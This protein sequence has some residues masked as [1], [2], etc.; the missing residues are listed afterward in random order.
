MNT[1]D[2]RLS[3]RIAIGGCISS[4]KSTLINAICT[5]TYSDM[6]RKRTT[7]KPQ[8]YCETKNELDPI[9]LNSIRENNKNDNS[10]IYK[11]GSDLTIDDIT[12]SVYPIPRIPDFM[13]LH[14]ECY[15]DLY[16]L[17]GLNDSQTQDVFFQYIDRNHLDFDMIIYIVDVCSALNTTDEMNILTKFL[18]VI[19]L[20]RNSYHV[21]KKNTQQSRISEEKKPI[22]CYNFYVKAVYPKIKKELKLQKNPIDEGINEKDFVFFPKGDLHHE[23]RIINIAT[24]VVYNMNL[25][26]SLMLKN[27]RPHSKVTQKR[28]RQLINLGLRADIILSQRKNIKSQDIICVAASRWSSMGVSEKE[29]WQYKYIAHLESEDNFDSDTI[30]R[31]PPPIKPKQIK[32]LVVLNKID[33]ISMLDSNGD[34]ELDEEGKELI[35]QAQEYITKE[36]KRRQL[37]EQYLGTT[38]LCAADAYI[39]RLY[40][41]NPNVKLDINHINRFGMN[42]YGKRTWSRF[43]SQQKEDKVRQLM[44]DE[45]GSNYNERMSACGFTNLKRIIN[46]SFSD[47]HQVK[48]LLHRLTRHIHKNINYIEGPKE[49]LDNEIIKWQRIFKALSKVDS[50]YNEITSVPGGEYVNEEER[51]SSIVESDPTE[52]TTQ[53]SVSNEIL[54]KLIQTNIIQQF[55]ATYFAPYINNIKDIYCSVLDPNIWTED[56]YESQREY[57]DNLVIIGNMLNSFNYDSEVSQLI[58]DVNKNLN[59]Y[60]EFSARSSHSFSELFNKLDTLVDNHYADIYTLTKEI[61]FGLTGKITNFSIGF[62]KSGEIIN[63][64]SH[65]YLQFS[66][67]EQIEA[68]QEFVINYLDYIITT[69]L[70]NEEPQKLIDY[71]CYLYALRIYTKHNRLAII[72]QNF[73]DLIENLVI[74]AIFKLTTEDAIFLTSKQ[75]MNPNELPEMDI[76]KHLLALNSSELAANIVKPIKL[77]EEYSSFE[78]DRNPIGYRIPNSFNQDTMYIRKQIMKKI[79]EKKPFKSPNYNNIL[80]INLN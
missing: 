52:G 57:R 69:D 1:I 26:S 43:T 54:P 62:R 24:G 19:Q 6:Q 53:S 77:E 48:L 41:Q 37:G 39:Y 70:S 68:L 34:A 14:E 28:I 67:I 80:N 5:K 74:N 79:T 46:T 17:P 78:S 33:E 44:R 20:A 51:Y 71:N 76:I 40:N 59:S 61:L 32:F 23:S 11:K 13:N 56:V 50:I 65:K 55:I 9:Y 63:I 21:P 22:S 29:Q 36:V 12:P 49:D 47:T 35:G 38:F 25:G 18:D 60:L 15:L 58:I 16:D 7:M 30:S 42:E 72:N 66:R 8:I 27:P 45:S 64:I 73:N 2:E 31:H 3:L 75:L 4:G 10:E